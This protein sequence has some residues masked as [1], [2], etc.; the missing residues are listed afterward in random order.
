MRQHER[1]V[2]GVNHPDLSRETLGLLVGGVRR[3]QSWPDVDE[4]PDVRLHDQVADRANEESAA[5]T[6]LR[7]N[8]RANFVELVTELSV[9]LQIV[10]VSEQISPY[11]RRVRRSAVESRLRVNFHSYSFSRA[12][13]RGA[14]RT[15]D[16]VPG[17]VQRGQHVTR[18]FS[19]VRLVP[20]GV[21]QPA[22]DRGDCGVLLRFAGSRG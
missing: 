10:F 3:G 4:L 22:H 8:L 16:V 15:A 1:V 12:F 21:R 14:G 13:R 9:G 17:D 18:N 11:P 5:R 2:I 6:N 20:V 19:A 7:D